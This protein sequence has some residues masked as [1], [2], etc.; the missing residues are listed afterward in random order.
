MANELVTRNG[1]STE[2]T[3]QRQMLTPAEAA[4]ALIPQSYEEAVK[5][6]NVFGKSGMYKINN[7]EQAMVILLIGMDMRITPSVAFRGIHIIDGKPSP[8]ADLMVGACKA[9]PELCEYF[10]VVET[11]PEIATFETKRKGDRTPVRMSFTIDEARN[12]QLTGK[13]NWKKYPAA[14]LRARAASSLA[15][16]V[17]P[18]ITTGLY[19]PDE[20]KNGSIEIDAGYADETTDEP[21]EIVSQQPTSRAELIAKYNANIL[22]LAIR[23][24]KQIRSEI[25]DRYK[26]TDSKDLSEDDLQWCISRAEELSKEQPAVK[27]AN[28]AAPEVVNAVIVEEPLTH[29]QSRLSNYLGSLSAELRDDHWATIE[30][31][32]NTRDIRKMDDDACEWAFDIIN[33]RSSRG[34]VVANDE[35]PF[36]DAE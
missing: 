20:L 11:T 16:L 15:R 3:H 31:Q 18:E 1:N 22:A 30:K 4:A 25:L 9:R 8:G 13:D 10:Q 14:M 33:P 27:T 5:M 17:Y 23:P 24:R 36:A 28:E 21:N 35:D 7:P 12:A 19:T 2:I 32:C 29:A 26:S 6:A 34:E